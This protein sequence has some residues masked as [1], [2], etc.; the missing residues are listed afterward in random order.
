MQAWLLRPRFNSFSCAA[1]DCI[2]SKT[3][4]SIRN[5]SETE[6]KQ[7][8]AVTEFMK[9][10][11]VRDA[12]LADSASQGIILDTST[13]AGAGCAASGPMRT[14]SLHVTTPSGN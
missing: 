2:L 4:V 13:S 3:S 1:I 12:L 11:R 7:K 6:D 10:T 8:E 14:F 5:I 9:R